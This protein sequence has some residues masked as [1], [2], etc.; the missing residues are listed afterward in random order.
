[1]GNHVEI[2]TSEMKR[3]SPSHPKQLRKTQFELED[4]ADQILSIHDETR[5]QFYF[6]LIK[7]I[8]EENYDIGTVEEV[9]QIFGGYINMTFG[10]YTK[11][12]GERQ[13][14][15]FRKYKQG[16]EL[17]SLLFEHRMLTHAKEN[18]FTY[19]ATPQYTRDNKTFHETTI[20]IG[21][22]EEP[23][24]FAVFNYIGGERRY[25]WI[26]NWAQDGLQDATILSA[27]RCMAEFHS[28][29]IDFDPQGLHGDNIMDS[30]DILVN[31]LIAKYPETLK[32]YRATYEK[33]E[34]D[35]PFIELFDTTYERYSR[36]CRENTI[37]ADDY[38][39]MLVCPC[40]CDFHP[41]NFKYYEDGTVSGSFDYDM[42]KFDSR[43]FEI[44]FGMHYCF[45]SWKLANDGEM[46]L[47]RVEKFI[48][49][50]NKECID[51]GVIPPLNATE[52]KYLF[53][54]MIQGTIYDYC[55]CTAAVYYDT[56]LDPFEYLYY[57][58]HFV[59]CLDWLEAHEQ[60]IR[61][62]ADKI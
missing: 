62:L 9:Y 21:D 15:L 6:S 56:T 10:I 61:A 49:A 57:S 55:W 40:H 8:V 12:D 58:Q 1:M 30:E 50:Y 14:W 44:G 39:E 53:E 7:K 32:R 18:G 38:Q 22:K 3:Y 25:D 42:A 17:D 45:A 34:L 48:N 26:P 36:L 2:N 23:F 47:D 54:V 37:P 11:K 51:I 35:N 52:K 29:G 13:T 60:E 31:D 28:A 33:A 19:G 16:K 24:L 4:T 43:L 20:Q 46:K 5:E 27:A 41:G 59:R